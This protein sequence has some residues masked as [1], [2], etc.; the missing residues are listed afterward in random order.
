MTAFDKDY[1]EAIGG[2]A[3]AVLMRRMARI[4]ELEAKG[5]AFRNRFRTRCIAQEVARLRVEYDELDMLV[6]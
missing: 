5:K 3:K 4:E 2:D 6:G 1:R